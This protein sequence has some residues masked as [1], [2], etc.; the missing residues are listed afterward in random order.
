MVVE[1]THPA[2]RK[3]PAV[4]LAEA[5]VQE[6]RVGLAVA[7][8]VLAVDREDQAAVEAAVDQVGAEEAARDLI[9]LL[10]SSL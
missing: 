3:D 6:A 1:L 5:E 9:N 4:G 10:R 7:V 2:L 8:V